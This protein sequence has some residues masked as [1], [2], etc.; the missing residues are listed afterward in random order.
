[1]FPLKSS[2]SVFVIMIG[3]MQDSPPSHDHSAQESLK[4]TFGTPA[5]LVHRCLAFLFDWFLVSVLSSVL[6]II[7][8]FSLGLM[9]PNLPLVGGL[10]HD[11]AFHIIFILSLAGYTGWFE[12]GVDQATPGKKL[13]GLQVVLEDGKV[14]SLEHGVLRGF[15]KALS[16]Y[17]LFLG[18]L[19]SLVHKDRKS[20][21]DILSSSM[22]LKTGIEHQTIAKILAKLDY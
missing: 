3:V 7:Y 12:G 1:M 4:P 6:C 22:V 10:L 2:E 16:Y 11:Y 19:M 5:P 20:L 14:L 13:C 17:L 8:M 21:H 15:L 9:L 18:F